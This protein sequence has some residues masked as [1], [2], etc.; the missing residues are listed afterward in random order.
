[1]RE[2]VIVSGARTAIGDYMGSLSGQNAVGL[3]II[4]LK[5]AIAKAGI[6]KNL[7]QEL[8]AG[9]VNQAGAPGNR[10]PPHRP[11]AQLPIE[12]FAF[13]VHQQC[14]SSMRAA[15]LLSQEITLGKVDIGAVVG[16]ESMSNAPICSSAPAKAT[17]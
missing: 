8:I 7:I 17:A 12:S 6:D 5:G 13:T 4:A 15:E 11:G 9:H 2:V 10:R 1:M 3:G 14:P 16:I